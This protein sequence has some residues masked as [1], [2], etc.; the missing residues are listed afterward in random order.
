MGLNNETITDQVVGPNLIIIING[1]TWVHACMPASIIA[2]PSFHW[3]T[4]TGPLTTQ[5][6]RHV[7]MSGGQV[8]VYFILFHFCY[9]IYSWWTFILF[10]FNFKIKIIFLFLFL[11]KK[12]EKEKLI[13][14]VGLWMSMSH[15]HW[16]HYFRHMYSFG[17][18]C[19]RN[20]VFICKIT[21]P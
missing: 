17:N 9:K 15:R 3:G 21:F 16:D 1:R 13:V 5:H 11:R 7:D 6:V 14:L 12:M 19:G 20:W 2:W 18:Y 10:N 8:S 4:C